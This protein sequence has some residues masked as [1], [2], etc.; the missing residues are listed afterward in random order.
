VFYDRNGNE[1]GDADA[2]A[3]GNDD[4]NAVE[5]EIP[6]VVG[7]ANQIPGVDMANDMQT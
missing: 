6:G 7:D 3:D 5:Y 1:I 2:E 4:A